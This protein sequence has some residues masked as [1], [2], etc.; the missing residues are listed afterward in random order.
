MGEALDSKSQGPRFS[1]V[2]PA[3]NR[4]GIV[5]RA[6]QSALDQSYAPFEI[7]V[8]DDGSTDR[9][10]EVIASFGAPVTLISREN[11]GA[12]AARNSGVFAAQGEWIA[13]L[14]SDDYW[15]E[16]HLKNM[17]AAIEATDG[18]GE[19]YFADI[20]MAENEGAR[21]Q[22]ERAEFSIEGDFQ[23]LED[24]TPWVLRKRVPLLLQAAVF[25]RERLVEAGGLWEVLPMRDDTHVFLRH[26]IAK[27]ICAVAGI[28]TIQ[29]SDDQSGGRL[30][31]T[32]SNTTQ[33]Y[34]RCSILMWGDL[35]KRVPPGDLA[36]RRLLEQRLCLSHI[37]F[38]VKA[39][40]RGHIHSLLI[41]G[42][43]AFLASPRTVL[44]A[45]GKKVGLGSNE[46]LTG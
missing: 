38:G 20:H 2:I 1:V 16:D 30:T 8:A 32:I 11:G 24:G 4:E 19:F 29:T 18:R 10:A 9:T 26:G 27:P 17:A 46:N 42:C 3:Y 6:I 25:H 44:S 45:L 5:G 41:H 23:L 43:K 7:L 34:W 37:R 12:P 36:S 15:T 35:L 13:F 39:A 40:K 33:R 28:G 21:P 14:D 22:W 31:T